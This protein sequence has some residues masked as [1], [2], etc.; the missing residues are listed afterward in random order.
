[1]MRVFSKEEDTI[2]FLFPLVG[3]TPR[4]T[5]RNGKDQFLLMPRGLF[6]R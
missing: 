4:G 1:M 3:L 2:Y 5:L 6:P